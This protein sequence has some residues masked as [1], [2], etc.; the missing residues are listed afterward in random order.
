[1]NFMMVFT[2]VVL[3]FELMLHILVIHSCI[4]IH[5]SSVPSRGSPLDYKVSKHPFEVRLLLSYEAGTCTFG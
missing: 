5:P 2:R 1:M 4:F 3:A